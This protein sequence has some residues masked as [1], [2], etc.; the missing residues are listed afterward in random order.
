MEASG[1]N[2][3]NDNNKDNT[4]K[5]NMSLNL[6]SLVK[7]DP[8]E[9]SSDKEGMDADSIANKIATLI[10]QLFMGGTQDTAS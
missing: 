8:K 9:S 1:Q 6:D 2:K 4:S 10:A 5:A 7:S 3:E